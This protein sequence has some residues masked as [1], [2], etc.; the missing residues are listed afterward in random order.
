MQGK[1]AIVLG[2]NELKLQEILKARGITDEQLKEAQERDIPFL[3]LSI[4]LP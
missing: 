4:I 2:D 1:Q 3:G